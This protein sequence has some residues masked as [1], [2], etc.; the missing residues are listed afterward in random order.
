MPILP[1]LSALAVAGLL[2]IPAVRSQAGSPSNVLLV[3]NR[4]EPSVAVNPRDPRMIVLTTNTDYSAS[5]GGIYPTAYFT[6]HN[7]GRS[8]LQGAAPEVSPYV[9][10]ADPTAAIDRNGTVFYSYLSE[11]ASYC[12]T[13]HSA[14]MLSHSTDGG[15]SFRGPRIVDTNGADDKPNM[16]VESH[17]GRPSH[18]FVTWTRFHDSTRSTDVWYARSMDGGTS[19]RRTLLYT[20]RGDN[21]GS[22]PVNGRHGRIYVFWV[23][24]IDKS[25]NLTGSTRI[26]FRASRNDGRH[27]GPVRQAGSSFQRVP[28]EAS[29]GA[30]RN[31]T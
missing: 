21:L 26:L 30:L 27:F 8:F 25:E 18:V 23:S 9:V 15:R 7:S 12:S 17:R 6:S 13:G 16:A 29:P 11:T 24:F 31:L 1:S 20:S 22:V 2:L 14:V 3:R 5:T 28:L 4:T 10:G 19:F